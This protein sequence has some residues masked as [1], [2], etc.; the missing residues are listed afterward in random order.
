MCWSLADRIGMEERVVEKTDRREHFNTYYRYDLPK[1]VTPGDVVNIHLLQY[2]GESDLLWRI[3]SSYIKSMP[4]LNKIIQPDRLEV[5]EE[6]FTKAEDVMNF[7]EILYFDYLQS[8]YYLAKAKGQTDMAYLEHIA[9]EIISRNEVDDYSVLVQSMYAYL[10]EGLEDKAVK[11]AGDI[12]SYLIHSYRIREYISDNEK[13]ERYM[14][15]YDAVFKGAYYVVN[16]HVKAESKIEY[17]VNYKHAISEMIKLRNQY[18]NQKITNKKMHLD[19]KTYQDL[20]ERIPEETAVLDYL[21]VSGCNLDDEISKY[22]APEKTGLFMTAIIKRKDGNCEIYSKEVLS[23]NELFDRIDKLTDILQNPQKKYRKSAE[24]VSDILLK[25]FEKQLQDVKNIILSL[26]RS[27]ANLP[28]EILF[29]VSSDSF[30]FEN[31]V[32]MQS[33][34]SLFEVWHEL[35]KYEGKACVI[36]NPAFWMDEKPQNGNAKIRGTHTV[37]DLSGLPYSGYEAV[38]IAGI[39][40]G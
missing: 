30:T 18:E 37:W 29:E 20:V 32:Y 3:Y 24:C 31:I 19:Y 28:F 6:A 21:C 4:R 11:Q 40:D 1:N 27:L 35:K 13:A 33:L 5:I 39:S 9:E 8:R 25:P 17:S 10:D 38:L 26:D 15:K 34:R 22:N 36:G 12:L 16:S 7:Q 2:N 23:C 14:A